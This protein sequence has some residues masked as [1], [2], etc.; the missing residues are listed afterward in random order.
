M[1]LIANLLLLAVLITISQSSFSQGADNSLDFDN[2]NY[3]YVEIADDAALRPSNFTI[4]TWFK[5]EASTGDHQI[6]LSK[7]YG[8]TAANSYALYCFQNGG[9]YNLRFYGFG[10][11]VHINSTNFELGVWHHAAAT[12]NGTTVYLYLNG[13]QVASATQGSSPLYDS[14][15]VLIGADNDDSNND[16]E[17][18][19][20]GE[21]DE[22]RI[23]NTARTA[24]QIRDNMN[25]TLSGS[26]TNLVAYWNF[27]SGS[28]TT[29]SD[30]TSNSNDG[31]LGFNTG[32]SNP[33]WVTSTAKAG[34]ESIFSLA[35]SDISEK[36]GCMVDIDLS[37]EGSSYSYSVYQVNSTPNST[38]GLLS[39][40]ATK[41]WEIKA[42]DADFDGTFTADIDFHFDEVGGITDE[43]NL[44]LY[45]R[46][47][48]ADN[49]WSEV[50]ITLFDESNNTDGNGY[51]RLS[52]DE[53]TAGDFS[54]QYIITS[55]DADNETLPVELLS[56]NA[57]QKEDFVKIYWSTASEKNSDY[58]IVQKSID[59]YNW[60]DI[61]EIDAQGNSNSLKNYTIN[62]K[63][64]KISQTIYYRLKQFDFNGDVKVY[65]SIDVNF[66]VNNQIL[67]YYQDEEN[68]YI[69]T[70]FEVREILNIRLITLN[71][72]VKYQKFVDVNPTTNSIQINKPNLSSG[73]YILNI[74]NSKDINTTLKFVEQ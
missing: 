57:K 24:T 50:T 65:K 7:Q 45:R 9:N 21:I 40:V 31:S 3:S 41:Y 18:F 19:F 27:D 26:E 5:I 22:V 55:S 62:D 49:T 13:I 51:L 28:G 72:E 43:S 69:E 20:N 10:S 59:G 58:F 38:S 29:L 56:F 47:D 8:T 52:I 48:A 42:S 30:Q 32:G 64:E 4:E 60:L 66:R 35:D 34:D 61:G 16:Y 37:N 68:I 2:S 63:P 33:T 54:G 17:F 25:K 73:I 71:G 1:K 12:Y 44:K 15:P 36:S 6:I 53:S 39:Y 70:S 23:W 67:N 11:S 74:S 14:N 46:D